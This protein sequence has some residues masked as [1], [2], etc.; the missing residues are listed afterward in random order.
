M[1]FGFAA[2]NP[3]CPPG[4]RSCAP[5]G[6]VATSGGGYYPPITNAP[7]VPPEQFPVQ[8]Q[9]RIV[10]G[11]PVTVTTGGNTLNPF[12]V[13]GVEPDYPYYAPSAAP[14]LVAPMPAPPAPMVQVAAPK[15][16]SS[17][18]LLV[19]GGILAKVFFF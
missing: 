14:A 18:P 13:P 12:P 8:T 9:V 7:W 3:Y 10:D 19:V 15:A 17:W 6:S 16:Q 5:D 11:Q 2:D 4:D 1:V